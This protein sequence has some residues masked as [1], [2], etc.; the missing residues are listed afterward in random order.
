[1]S[2]EARRADLIRSAR[3]DQG[4]TPGQLAR[5]ADVSASTVLLAEEGE[6]VRPDVLASIGSALG[7]VTLALPPDEPVDEHAQGPEWVD[8][9]P[10]DPMHERMLSVM[11]DLVSDR[12][13]WLVAPDVDA[14]ERDV[15]Y[16][17]ARRAAIDRVH[18][19]RKVVLP[20]SVLVA[21]V[22]ACA[23]AWL[24]HLLAE[25]VMMIGMLGLLGVMM[26]ILAL[27]GTPEAAWREDIVRKRRDVL[28]R[29]AFHVSSEG[30]TVMAVE[31]HGALD[32]DYPAACIV[33]TEVTQAS[34]GHVDVLVRTIHGDVSMPHIPWHRRTMD[35]IEG[36]TVGRK[37][38]TGAATA[39]G[40]RS[41][42]C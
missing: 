16:S 21:T 15:G 22:V 41:P 30:L 31:D 5:R 8:P 1:M 36:W 28:R 40:G 4:L 19:R 6:A 25:G 27:T 42:K 33:G 10:Q 13:G 18:A 7:I 11:A 24:A 12:P 2:V 14:W 29:C 32:R 37:P 39:R 3:L 26:S 17:E 20:V 38:L 34:G 35:L 23:V 9:H